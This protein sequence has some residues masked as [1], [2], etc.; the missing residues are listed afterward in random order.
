MPSEPLIKPKA[1][2]FLAPDFVRAM[3]AGHSALGLAFAALIY[4]V[5]ISGAMSVF[6]FELQ[7]WEQP[8]AP[9]VA[10]TPAPDAIAAAVQ[11]GY[12]QARAD[13]AAHDLF[14]AGPR[15]VPHGGVSNTT[16][17]KPATKASGWPTSTAGW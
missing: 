16:T 4:V 13:N 10:R 17:M 7:R 11:A 5:C 1:R 12:A 14:V 6:L 2:P 8:N 3:L 9:L 15:R